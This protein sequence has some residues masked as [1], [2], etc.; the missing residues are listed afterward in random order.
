V[1]IFR[2][3]NNDD[4]VSAIRGRH[5]SHLVSITALTQPRG[6][7]IAD[8]AT[9]D[10]LIKMAKQYESK[11]MEFQV[12]RETQYLLWDN[13]LLY[14]Y[15]VAGDPQADGSA[16]DAKHATASATA[17]LRHARSEPYTG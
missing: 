4:E 6:A 2:R 12:P 3:G 8:V 17:S 5:G 16:E 9:I 13:G 11:I 15:R 1:A 10:D 14:R 7:T